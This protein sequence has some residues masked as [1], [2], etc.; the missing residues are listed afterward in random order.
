MESSSQPNVLWNQVIDGAFEHIGSQIFS[1]FTFQELANY[2][3][4]CRSWKRF[5][6]SQHYWCKKVFHRV[7]SR[8]H[9]LVTREFN[10]GFAYIKA[11]PQLGMVL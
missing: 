4:V 9:S 7:K 11:N 3:Q 2:R 1:H 10:P 5:I 8:S 6:S